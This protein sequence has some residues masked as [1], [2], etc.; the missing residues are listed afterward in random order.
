MR[1]LT[2]VVRE[3]TAQPRFRTTLVGGFAVIAII[4]ALVGLHGALAFTVNQR[5]QE[6]GV[7][8]LP[9]VRSEPRSSG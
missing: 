7:R 6:F 8:I 5:R 3:S 4:L 9:S 1:T 2:D